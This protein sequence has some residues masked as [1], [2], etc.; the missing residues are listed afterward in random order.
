MKRVAVL[1]CLL[2]FLAIPALGAVPADPGVPAD[3]QTLVQGN[4]AFAL[5]LY[6]HLRDHEGNLFYS[7]YSIST[8][9][10]MTYAGARGET[11]EQMAQVL[12][13]SLDSGRLHPAVAELIRDLH[14]HGL[15]RDYRL[16][17]AQSLWGDARL[18]VRPEFASLIHTNYGA[19]LRLMDFQHQPDEVRQRINRWVEERTNDKIKDLLHAG[20]LDGATRLVLVNAIYFKAAWQKP[21]AKIATQQ[22][23]VFHTGGKDVKAALMHQAGKFNYAEGDGVQA[24]ELPYEDG[25]LSMVVLLPR[26]NDGLG[27]LEKSLTAAKLDDWLR[28]RAMREVQVALPR[29]KL[30]A[31]FDLGGEL[32]AMGMPLAFSPAADFSGM[33]TN[34]RLMISKVIHQA[35]V[36]VDEAGTEAAAA[37]AVG[38]KRLS[39]PDGAPVVFRADHPFL[40]LLRDNHTGSILFLGRV[41]DPSAGTETGKE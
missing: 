41:T 36:E 2:P 9:L 8:A 13:F 12:H 4:N 30:A 33:S 17:V 39:L 37:T 1:F 35:F 22:D 32:Q 40:F 5:D 25:E 20:D 34:E 21:F 27:K 19:H 26:D 24:L 28:K 29:F 7:P 38:M 6:A 3:V 23:A 15:P 18:S 11:A 10:A 16:D 31:R 14:G